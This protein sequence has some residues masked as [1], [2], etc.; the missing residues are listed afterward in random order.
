MCKAGQPWRASPA[1]NLKHTLNMIEATTTVVPAP[2]EIKLTAAEEERF[3]SKVNKDG[4][5]IPHMETPCWVWTAGKLKG[6]GL[7]KIG[8]KKLLAHRVVWMISN[9]PIP[10]DGS[11]HGICVCH[12]CD[13]P[14]CCN[15][16]HL[17]LGTNADNAADREAK[18]RNKLTPARLSL[19]LHPEKRP[20]GEKHS[21]AK[22]TDSEASYARIRYAEGG[23][24]Q[25]QLAAQFG[26]SNVLISLIIRRKI[27]AHLP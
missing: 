6:Y 17:F 12:R 25:R 4:P 9:G 15:P 16:S 18:G 19:E 23:I 21:M 13:N 7:V 2:Q 24:T 10:H 11:Y 27:W 22:L 26:V 5:T 8:N 20:R 14:A 1:S 3:W